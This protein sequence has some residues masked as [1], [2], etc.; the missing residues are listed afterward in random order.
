MH[1]LG[2]ITTNNQ[3]NIFEGHS[4][5]CREKS[6]IESRIWQ[7]QE[8]YMK[9]ILTVYRRSLTPYSLQYCHFMWR[10]F[11]S[12]VTMQVFGR[13]FVRSTNVSM[14]YKC[15]YVYCTLRNVLYGVFMVKV[16]KPVFDLRY[17]KQKWRCQRNLLCSAQ[18]PKIT[19]GIVQWNTIRKGDIYL[20]KVHEILTLNAAQFS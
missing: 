15:Y 14:R 2:S 18:K 5:I 1:Y 12:S 9:I 11:G 20:N 4:V 17:N 16:Y 3:I 13:D 8:S 19:K 7:S 6:Q 10:E